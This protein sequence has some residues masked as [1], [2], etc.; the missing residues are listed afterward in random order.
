MSH[1][2][3]TVKGFMKSCISSA[4]DGTDETCLEGDGDVRIEWEKDEI[5]DCEENSGTDW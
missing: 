3:I 4:L 5:T 2:K 1:V